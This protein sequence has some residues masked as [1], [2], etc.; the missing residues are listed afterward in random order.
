[1][2]SDCQFNGRAGLASA[3]K[4]GGTVVGYMIVIYNTAV[5]GYRQAAC[6]HGACI[7]SEA[8]IQG[9]YI[10]GKISTEKAITLVAIGQG[11]AYID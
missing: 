6:S 7:Y 8:A 2:A 5:A 11:I 1:M 4:T 10:A 9:T 3:I